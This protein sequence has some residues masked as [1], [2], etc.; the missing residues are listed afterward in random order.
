MACTKELHI[1]NMQL[2][3]LHLKL[4]GHFSLLDIS[5]VNSMVTSVTC[6]YSHSEIN[7]EVYS[8]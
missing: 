7:F 6:C 5:L 1:N 2:I 4:C 3:K 8:M